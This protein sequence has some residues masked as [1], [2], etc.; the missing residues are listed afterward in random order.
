MAKNGLTSGGQ[1]EVISVTRLLIEAARLRQHEALG[2]H[3]AQKWKC[4]PGRP[5]DLAVGGRATTV[6]HGEEDVVCAWLRQQ[7]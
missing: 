1:T 2:C 6:M 5:S 3:R 7:G 4:P